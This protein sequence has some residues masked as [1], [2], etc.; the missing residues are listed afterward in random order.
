MNIDVR[1]GGYLGVRNGKLD[2]RVGVET[3]LRGLELGLDEET[4]EAYLD[5]GVQWCILGT[6]AVREPHLVS[7]ICLEF[8]G[9]IIVDSLVDLPIALGILAD[10]T[11]QILGIWI[12]QTEGAKFWLSVFNE[13]KTRGVEDCFIACVDGLK[14]LPEAIEAVYPQTQVQL[15]IVHKLRNS[16]RSSLRTP[17][18]ADQR[19]A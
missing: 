9:H 10:G 17:S 14:G 13:L 3:V 2:E 16:F 18:S 19:L 11:K 12:E 1:R 7:E 5:A 15:C 4:I 6:K 8:P